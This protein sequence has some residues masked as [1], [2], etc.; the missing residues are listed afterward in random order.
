MRHLGLE[1]SPLGVAQL[2]KGLL[3]G[4]VIDDVDKAVASKINVLGMKVAS[5]QTIMDS[6]AARVRLAEDTL[7]LAE[8]L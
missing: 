4:F 6:S 3:R 8:T 5:T 2:Y 1:V 7:K